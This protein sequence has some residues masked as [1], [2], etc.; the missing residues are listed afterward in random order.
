LLLDAVARKKEELGAHRCAPFGMPNIQVHSGDPLLDPALAGVAAI[1]RIET[2]SGP[3]DD[4]DRK[5]IK[6]H[7]QK[8]LDRML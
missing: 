5:D 3:R 1:K 7:I 4:K 2:R 6:A 8:R